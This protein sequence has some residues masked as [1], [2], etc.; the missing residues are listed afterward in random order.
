MGDLIYLD[1]RRAEHSSPPPPAKP[2]F[3]FDLTCPESYLVAERIER[4]LG[5]TEWIPLDATALRGE[6]DAA[7]LHEWRKQ[8]ESVARTQ[9]LPLVWPERFPARMPCAL[10]AAAYACELGAGPSFAL[11]AF[12]LAFCGGFDLEDP[13][14]LAEAAAVARVPL[15]EC[16]SAAGETWRD[17]ELADTAEALRRSGLTDVP[18]ICIDGQW[19]AGESGL[20]AASAILGT[21]ETLT[22]PLAPVG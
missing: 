7:A 6:P 21:Q 13:E 18:A 5:E 17:E 1:R 2:M 12:R 11:A 10:R 16:L 15:D 19:F 20:L 3:V 4:E 14:A 8:A 22:R 9:R